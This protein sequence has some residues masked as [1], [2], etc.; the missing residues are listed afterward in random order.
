MDKLTQESLVNAL[1]RA[2]IEPVEGDLERFDEL[3][4]LYLAGLDALNA[5]DLGDEEIAP[6][7]HPD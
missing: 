5:A 3:I 2:G 7:F 4:A 1:A 6:V